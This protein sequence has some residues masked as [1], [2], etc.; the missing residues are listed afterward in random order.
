MERR[1]TAAKRPA[2]KTIRGTL[3]QCAAV[4]LVLC[5]LI[6]IAFSVIVSVINHRAG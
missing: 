5:I 2:V 1:K 4:I 6:F 3:L